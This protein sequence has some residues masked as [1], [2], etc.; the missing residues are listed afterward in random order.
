MGFTKEFKEF[1]LKGNV[2]DLAIAVILGAAFGKIVTSL[3]ENIIMPIVGSFIGKSVDT[4]STTINGVLIKYGLFLQTVID[5]I[6]IALVIFMI[7]KTMNKMK[8]KKDVV[9]TTPEM[10]STDKLLVEIRDAVRK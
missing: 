3:V 4:W 1:A 5:F 8:K 9:V 7:V 6:I 10:S 2:M